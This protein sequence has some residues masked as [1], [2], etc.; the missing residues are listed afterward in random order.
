MIDFFLN[1][2]PHKLRLLIKNLLL[3]FPDQFKKMSQLL[4]NN[5]KVINTVFLDGIT[6]ITKTNNPRNTTFLFITQA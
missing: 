2:F 6:N 4:D 3:I 5:H 1:K